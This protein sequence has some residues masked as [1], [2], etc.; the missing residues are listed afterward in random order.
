[1]KFAI[2]SMLHGKLLALLLLALHELWPAEASGARAAAHCRISRN[3]ISHANAAFTCATD[4][5]ST[6]LS[7]FLASI[8][9]STCRMKRNVKPCDNL[10]KEVI[11]FSSYSGSEM[12]GTALLERNAA[13]D[14]FIGKLGMQRFKLK[15]CFRYF[16][17][18]KLWKQFPV[19]ST[20]AD[21]AIALPACI[22]SWN[23]QAGSS[24]Q[25][26]SWSSVQVGLQRSTLFQ[27]VLLHPLDPLDPLDSLDAL[28]SLDSLLFV[29]SWEA[30]PPALSC[31]RPSQANSGVLPKHQLDKF[32]AGKH[33]GACAGV[34]LSNE[35]VG[36]SNSSYKA[37]PEYVK[38]NSKSACSPA[39]TVSRCVQYTRQRC[40]LLGATT[41]FLYPTR[42]W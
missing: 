13:S 11:P 22:E 39:S 23:G 18:S 26:N 38:P 9:K 15:N 17:E 21:T 16:E 35:P 6:C 40:T 14:R 3:R 36:R 12:I 10:W 33:L 30:S 29:Q 32:L 28:G 8:V 5:Q 4:K 41:L 31:T 25:V 37:A 24:G 34:P 1:M 20:A 2:T 19:L 42:A 27:S 7:A